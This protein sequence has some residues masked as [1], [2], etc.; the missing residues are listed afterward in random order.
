VSEATSSSGWLKPL[1]ARLLRDYE[2]YWIFEWDCASAPAHAPRAAAPC[3]MTEVDEAAIRALPCAPLRE[4]A[5]YAGEGA[6]AFLAT[7]DGAPAGLC[8][9]WYGARYRTRNFW[10]L[11]PGQAKLVQVM[12]DPVHRGHGVASALIA[13]SADVLAGDGFRTLFARVWH[14]NAPSIAAFRRAGWRRR[15]LVVAAMPAGMQRRLRVVLPVR[16]W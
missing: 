8:F 6:R 1:A 4:Q 2:I 5:W 16:G 14:S 7:L 11:R 15:A 12:V 10:P 13:H 3:A 9:Y